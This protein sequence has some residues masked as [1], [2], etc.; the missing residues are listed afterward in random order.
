MS[1]LQVD[2]NW[3]LREA[4]YCWNYTN[5][6]GVQ[7]V[8]ISYDIPNFK[9]QDLRVDF[10]PYASGSYANIRPMG[11]WNKETK[12]NSN[13]PRLDKFWL[14]L[15]GIPREVKETLE[16]P[17]KRDKNGV[18]NWRN[19]WAVIHSDWLMRELNA[20]FKRFIQGGEE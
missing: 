18:V 10:T 17:S 13:E 5:R 9:G 11:K 4:G 7:K 3:L 8:V 6:N 19:V 15:N 20:E 1:D 2:Y 16:K 12:E 14:D